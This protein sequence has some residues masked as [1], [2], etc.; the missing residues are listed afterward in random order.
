MDIRPSGDVRPAQQSNRH[1][2]CV[3]VCTLDTAM[4]WCLG[5]DLPSRSDAIPRSVFEV[6]CPCGEES[7]VVARAL[8]RGDLG[9][10]D[11]V[12]AAR[13]TGTVEAVNERDAQ[14]GQSIFGAGAT[15]A[16][17]L[18]ARLVPIRRSCSEPLSRD[19]AID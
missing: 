9:I 1:S 8:E 19:G 14:R 10:D 12:L 11:V 15:P 18:Y 7:D 3:G 4:G 6:V 16:R 13:L 17:L 5:C 2:P